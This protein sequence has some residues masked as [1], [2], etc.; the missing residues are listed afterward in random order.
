MAVRTGQLEK[1]SNS[2]LQKQFIK[3]KAMGKEQVWSNPSHR[4]HLQNLRNLHE[5]ARGN[6]GNNKRNP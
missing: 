3:D 4:R 2:E 6:H 5:Q 1:L